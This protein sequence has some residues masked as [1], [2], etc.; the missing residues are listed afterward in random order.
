MALLRYRGTLPQMFDPDGDSTPWLVRLAMIRHDLKF[1]ISQLGLTEDAGPDDVFRTT[2]FLRRI[3][4]SV[5]EA[6]SILNFNL[7]KFLERMADVWPKDLVDGLNERRATAAAAREKLKTVRDVIG[8]HLRPK[9][10]ATGEPTV[11]RD[12]LSTHTGWEVDV[13]IDT[14]TCEQTSMR[15]IGMA[16]FLFAWPEVKNDADLD[17]KHG[18]Y[19]AALLP[20]ARSVMQATDVLLYGY[21]R[22]QGIQPTEET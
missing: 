20:A 17:A 10:D 18:E 4:I 13:T 21:W 5:L 1:E 9:N 6:E 8:G 19:E 7:G 14:A 11:I 2:Y 12:V 22:E 16:A 3:S 15:D